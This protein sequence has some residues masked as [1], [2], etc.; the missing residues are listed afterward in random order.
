MRIAN[1]AGR[2]V[3]LDGEDVDHA[4]AV[5][6]ATASGS[7]DLPCRSRHVIWGMTV[8]RQTVATLPLG[9]A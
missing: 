4:R 9:I 7:M 5:D 3:L 1:A 8:A 2:L 6:V